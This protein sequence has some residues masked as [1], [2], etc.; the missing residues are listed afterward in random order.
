MPGRT[1]RRASSSPWRGRPTVSRT[2]TRSG[3]SPNSTAISLSTDT[4]G[5][6]IESFHRPQYGAEHRALIRLRH[7]DDHFHLKES[8]ADITHRLA[9]GGTDQVTA[10]GRK[11]IHQRTLQYLTLFHEIED[12]LTEQFLF[13]QAKKLLGLLVGNDDLAVGHE[14]D[15][16]R[17]GDLDKVAIAAFRF[18]PLNGLAIQLFHQHIERTDQLADLVLSPLFQTFR[19]IPGVGNLGDTG[20]NGLDRREDRS[21]DDPA[22]DQDEDHQHESVITE[23]ALQVCADL[24]VE[25]LHGNGNRYRTDDL[26]YLVAVGIVPAGKAFLDKTGGGII[27]AMAPQTGFV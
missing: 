24:V 27:G 7:G 3:R 14:G 13:V 23:V 5:I 16:R 20:G 15:D 22:A 11:I 9:G 4:R 6:R 25:P 10:A 19:K 26:A 18:D 2:G 8:A 1:E 12:A 21:A 17:L